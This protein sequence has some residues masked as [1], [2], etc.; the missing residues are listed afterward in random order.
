MTKRCKFVGRFLGT[1]LFVMAILTLP[2]PAGGQQ[3]CEKLASLNLPGTT[4]TAS[5][6]IPAGP[7]TTPPDVSGQTQTVDLPAFCRVAGVIAPTPDSKINFETW[8]PATTWNGKFEDLGN[9]GFAGFLVYRGMIVLLNRGY[10]TA[11]TDDGHTGSLDVS[12]AIGHPEKVKDF[13]YRAVHETAEKSEAII[14]AFYGKKLAHA[15]FNGCSDGGREALM[16]A[17]RFPE[18]FDG[19]I[20]GAPDNSWSHQLAGFIWDEQATAIDP[21][22]FIPPEKLPII[23]AAALS[24][25]SALDGASEGILEDPRQCYFDPA[26]IRCA[27]ADAPNCLTAPQVEAARKIYSG[28]KNPRTGEQVYPGYEPGSEADPTNWKPWITGAKQGSAIQF[29]FGNLFFGGMVFQNPKWDFRSFDFDKDVKLADEKTAA[30]LNSDNPDLS[31]FRARGGKLLQYHGW[32]DGAAAPVDS[33]D[34]YEKVIGNTA[35]SK[36]AAE[37]QTRTY[38][39]LFMVPGMAH[40]F[41]GSGANNFGNNW[42]VPNPNTDPDHDVISALD[43]WVEKGVAPEKLIATKFVDD[44]PEKGVARTHLLCPYPQEAKWTGKGEKKDAASYICQ[45]RASVVKNAAQ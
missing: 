25:C 38:Y 18:D 8:M 3:S 36:A 14:Q 42:G 23:Q 7:F 32:A 39:R 22:S 31:R 16:E 21:A 2:R 34:Y 12:W 28:P 9:G 17:Q 44:K 15:Y 20:A 29:F 13:G 5:T 40:C 37:Q 43:R 26:K 24:Q 19:I 11:S 45:S 30:V 41:N 33:I 35:D 4:I 27:D 10:A 1:I 6:S